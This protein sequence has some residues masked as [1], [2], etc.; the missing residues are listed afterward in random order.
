MIGRKVGMMRLYDGG[1]RVRAVTAI[2]LGPNRVTQL[3][4]DDRDG[5]AA[6]QVGYRGDRKRLTRPARGHLSQAGVE[7]PLG[8]LREFRTDDSADYSPGQELRVDRFSPGAFVDVSGVSKGKG[9]AGGVKRWGFHG[10][11]KTHGQSD[12]HRGPGSV[13]AGTTPGRVWKG[14][15]M[16]G[17]MGARNKTVRNLLVVLTDAD[18]NLLFVEGSVPGPRNGIVVV[19]VGRRSALRDYESPSPLPAFEPVEVGEEQQAE[20]AM[21]AA[22]AAAPAETTEAGEATTE[23][24]TATESEPLVEASVEEPSSEDAGAGEEA[25]E[26]VEQQT[27]DADDGA[28]DG[29]E[30]GAK[31]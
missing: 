3:R 30:D 7:E 2:E 29:A 12:K 9:F 26:P 17:H 27:E 28:E 4:S 31:E 14:Q 13:G 24:A 18:R 8:A 25:E 15:K 5:Y 11:P 22:D 19:R 16:A 6:V 23:T 21:E 20:A 1:G 10:G